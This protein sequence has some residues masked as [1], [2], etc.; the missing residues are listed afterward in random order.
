LMDGKRKKKKEN[1]MRK[2]KGNK[3]S[4]AHSLRELWSNKKTPN[5]D[6]S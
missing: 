6:R 3:V 2:K 1:G 4:C 5:K